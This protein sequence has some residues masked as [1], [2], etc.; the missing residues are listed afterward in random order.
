ML[1]ALFLLIAVLAAMSLWARMRDRYDAARDFD[2]SERPSVRSVVAVW[3]MTTTPAARVAVRLC[4][5][6]LLV[7]ITIGGSMIA[8]EFLFLG[9]PPWRVIYPG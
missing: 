6:V 5:Y 1:I 9:P 7:A 2:C 8:I 3:W 4:G